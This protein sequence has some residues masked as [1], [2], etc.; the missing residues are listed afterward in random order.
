M[1]SNNLT[2]KQL[3]ALIWVVDLGSFRRAAQHLNTTQPNISTRIAGL[4]KSL[5]VTL[6]QRDAGSV[7]L[8][9]KGVAF[10]DQARRVL[11]A[12]DGL[13]EI[14]ERP[15]LVQDRLRL[16]VTELVAYTWLRQFIRAM[17]DS[18]PNVAVELTID[19]SRTLDKDLVAHR[20]DLALQTAPF[21]TQISGEIALGTYPFVWVA[22][23]DI[24]RKLPAAPT[25]ADLATQVILAHARH[26]QAYVELSDRFSAVTSP[27]PRIAPSNS[28]MATL[29]MVLDGI[30]IAA[31]PKA[32]AAVDLAAGG[33]VELDVAWRPSPL[34]L[35]ARFHRD[36]AATHVLRAAEIAA[37]CAARALAED[38]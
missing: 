35:A 30:G 3:E 12:A 34:R 25:E 22:A 6:M 7:R 18:Y 10:L 28:L 1:I 38:I 23:P 33:L 24:A 19:F 17:T 26:T 11:A 16:G 21:A 29:H 4:E 14:A 36:K 32:M 20:L 31:V 9:P 15:D 27:R 2:L 8:T 37:E 13:V 5:G